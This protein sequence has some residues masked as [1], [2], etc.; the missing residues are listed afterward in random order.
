[1]GDYL[2]HWSSLNWPSKPFLEPL[3]PWKHLC[4]EID[5][6]CL[7]KIDRFW[8]VD[9]HNKNMSTILRIFNQKQAK[10]VYLSSN[11]VQIFTNNTKPKILTFRPDTGKAM[12]NRT[13]IIWQI[14]SYIFTNFSGSQ[15]LSTI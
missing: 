10:Q 8:S 9:I 14:Q 13:R 3:E 2:V 5:T 11:N 4:S 7:T 6:T 15:L 12:A 1:M